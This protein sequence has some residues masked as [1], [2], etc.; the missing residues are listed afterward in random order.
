V[1]HKNNKKRFIVNKCKSF[2]GDRSFVAHDWGHKAANLKG[3]KQFGDELDPKFSLPL[4]Y[5]VWSCESIASS[6]YKNN[7][8]IANS[9]ALHP[10][11]PVGTIC[12]MAIVQSTCVSPWVGVILGNIA[13]IERQ[14]HLRGGGFQC[15]TNRKHNGQ[16]M[17]RDLKCNPMISYDVVKVQEAF[18]LYLSQ[19]KRLYDPRRKICIDAPVSI[20]SQSDDLHDSSLSA[21]ERKKKKYLFEGDVDPSLNDYFLTN[22]DVINDIEIV[23]RQDVTNARRFSLLKREKQR[24]KGRQQQQMKS[25]S[26]SSSSSSF[27]TASI[28]SLSHSSSVSEDHITSANET[29]KQLKSELSASN[30]KLAA[31][32]KIIVAK[33]SELENL[34][35]TIKKNTDSHKQKLVNMQEELKKYKPDGRRRKATPQEAESTPAA[36]STPTNHGLESFA[37]LMMSLQNQNTDLLVTNKETKKQNETLEIKLKELSKQLELVETKS[38]A[39]YG[40]ISQL[41]RELLNMK[42]VVEQKDTLLSE[43]YDL[44]KKKEDTTTTAISSRRNEKIKWNSISM[45]DLI[46]GFISGIITHD[47]IDALDKYTYNSCVTRWRQEGFAIEDN[48]GALRVVGLLLLQQEEDPL[49]IHPQQLSQFHQPQ[50]H[51]HQQF[52]HQQV[53]PI[54]LRHHIHQQQQQHHNNTNNRRQPRNNN[55]Y[56]NNRNHHNLPLPTHKHNNTHQLSSMYYQSRY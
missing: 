32:E 43:Q 37:E 25:G 19:T 15:I 6:K 30:K 45:I 48:T 44:L 38:I 27:T 42:A 50:A 18:G 49:I 28:S 35:A 24:I 26:S 46:N 10:R 53:S 4:M 2:L 56:N 20:W 52:H 33:Q 3:K 9:V 7:I 29:I 47:D 54:P 5:N 11:F 21:E 1:P 13:A 23:C 14:E 55:N 8:L 36:E 16:Q 51:H 40:T 34:R 41:Q 31:S 39:D 22:E 17:L 12:I